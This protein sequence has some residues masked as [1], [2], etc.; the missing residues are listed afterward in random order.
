[1]ANNSNNPV[2]ITQNELACCMQHGQLLSVTM[3]ECPQELYWLYE[4]LFPNSNDR[5]RYHPNGKFNMIETMENAVGPAM[6]SSLC[7]P[8]ATTVNT[9]ESLSMESIEIPLIYEDTPMTVCE[10]DSYQINPSTGQPFAETDWAGKIRYLQPRRANALIK[11]VRKRMEIIAAEILTTGCANICGEN[12]EDMTIDYGRDA[13]NEI[14]IAPAD[15]WCTNTSMPLDMVDELVNSIMCCEGDGIIDWIMSRK[16]WKLLRNHQQIVDLMSKDA[17]A[18]CQ[19]CLVDI[20]EHP[21]G[22]KCIGQELVGSTGRHRFWVYDGGMQMPDG[23]GGFTYQSL[24]NEDDLYLVMR[25]S[26]M[27][28]RTY[29]GMKSMTGQVMGGT[30]PMMWADVSDECLTQSLKVRT[31][32]LPGNVNATMVIKGVGGAC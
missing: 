15:S 14:T 17:A 24:L 19:G 25:D 20:S 29:G 22:S 7:S 1:M 31:L 28:M 5:I 16:L 18:S 12:I 11:R 13:N 27:G 9:G 23:A 6:F 10:T 8:K 26:F 2:Q 30:Q 4:F 32:P 3:K 21:Y